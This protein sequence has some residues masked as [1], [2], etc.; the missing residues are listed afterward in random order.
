MSAESLY[1]HALEAQCVRSEGGGWFLTVHSTASSDF[2]FERQET[3]ILCSY[4]VIAAA[5]ASSKGAQLQLKLM[6]EDLQ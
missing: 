4:S 3:I 1:A 5:N 2:D 6:F